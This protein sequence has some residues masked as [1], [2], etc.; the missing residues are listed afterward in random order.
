[1]YFKNASLPEISKSPTCMAINPIAF[2]FPCS[3]R[4]HLLRRLLDPRLTNFYRGIPFRNYIRT[5]VAPNKKTDL[6][7]DVTLPPQSPD[8][9]FLIVLH[10]SLHAVLKPYS[11]FNNSQATLSPSTPFGNWA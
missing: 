7:N 8:R 9:Q 5:L 1:M 10:Q 6:S 3:Q 2:R 11:G 4:N